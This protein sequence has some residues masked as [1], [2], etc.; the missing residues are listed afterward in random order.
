M[1]ETSRDLVAV[2]S[3]SEEQLV[4]RVVQCRRAG[5]RAGHDDAATELAARVYDYIAARVRLFKHPQAG[6]AIPR[7]DRDDAAQDA[8][9][10]TLKM[11]D[12]LREPSLGAFRAALRTTVHNTCLDW[13]RRDMTRDKGLAGSVDDTWEGSEGDPVGRLDKPLADVAAELEHRTTA[14][15]EAADALDRAFAEL[16]DPRMREVIELTDAGFSSL[17]I[18]ERLD[19]KRDNVDQLRSRGYKRL[20]EALSR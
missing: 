10:R 9:L 19:L 20:R 12:N 8:Y 18:G 5:D 14:A 6:I 7:D 13:C 15:L 11:L 1:S 17:E 16:P 3:L 4:R 2:G